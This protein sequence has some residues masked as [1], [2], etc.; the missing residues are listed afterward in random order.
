MLREFSMVKSFQRLTVLC[1]LIP[2]WA[3]KNLV[4]SPLV[5]IRVK[6]G[7]VRRDCSRVNPFCE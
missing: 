2:K 5:S 1:Q 6:E 4:L 7:G 3:L